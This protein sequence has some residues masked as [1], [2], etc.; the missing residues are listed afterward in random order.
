MADQMTTCQAVAVA[1]VAAQ[2]LGFSFN[3][4]GAHPSLSIITIQQAQSSR[5]GTLELEVN[6]AGVNAIL[7][8]LPDIKNPAKLKEISNMKLTDLIFCE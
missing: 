6:L 8:P 3:V 5:S 4:A 7:P 1:A 2:A